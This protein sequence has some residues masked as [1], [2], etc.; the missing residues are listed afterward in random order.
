[1]T[2]R[3]QRLLTILMTVGAIVGCAKP[4]AEAEPVEPVVTAETAVLAAESFSE[5]VTGTGSV[6]ARSEGSA[7][8]GVPVAARVTKVR[9]VAGQ[10]VRAGDVL[11]ELDRTAIDAEASSAAAGLAAAD[12]AAK[13][14]QRLVDAGVLPRRDAEEAL[15]AAARARAVAATA[16]HTASLATL[17]APIAGVV[18][19][20]GAVVG[21]IADPALPLIE[22]AD[23]SRIDIVLTATATDAARITAGLDV[24]LLAGSDTVGDGRVADVG[25]AVDSLSRGVIVRIRVM[26][27]ARPLRIGETITGVV[28]LAPVIDAVVVPTI[29]LVPS[30]EGFQVFVV[31]PDGTAHARP[32][33]VGGTDA[34]RVRV[35]SGLR[36][37][38][39]IVTQGA[40]GVDDGVRI[41]APTPQP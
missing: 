34:D 19:R 6:V 36:A 10:R 12:A 3:W 1:M 39:R 35:T 22:I 28:R 18:T 26:A 30:G 21:T 7:A 33:K 8:L 27:S 31:D 25:S 16:R 17:R 24:I 9:V 13:R 38:E 5:T 23:P 40:Y 20:V 11:I 4:E 2:L 41:V 29:A 32:V 15:A 37:G 14:A